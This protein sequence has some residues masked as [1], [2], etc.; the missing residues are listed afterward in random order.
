MACA[1]TLAVGID[2]TSDSLS[3]PGI[4]VCRDRIS[5]GLCRLLAVTLARLSP[6]SR[7]EARTEMS[8]VV[9]LQLR[10]L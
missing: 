2:S 10:D 8:A 3:L 6:F 4:E 9:L 5:A 7:T 1:M